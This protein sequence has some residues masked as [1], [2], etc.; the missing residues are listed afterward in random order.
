MILV[1]GYTYGCDRPAELAADMWQVAA[2]FFALMSQGV[3]L[4]TTA[5]IFVHTHVDTGDTATL[6]R[7]RTTASGSPD[8]SQGAS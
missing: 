6:S 7:N 8:L 4:S 2:D 1:P 3:C 5:T